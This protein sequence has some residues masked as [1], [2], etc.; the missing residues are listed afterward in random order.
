MTAFHIPRRRL[1]Q[2]AAAATIALPSF[3]C[4]AQTLAR[5]LRIG[6]QKGYPGLLKGRR[7]LEALEA[8]AAGTA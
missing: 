1:R 2:G 3:A 4:F 5:V 7:T 6:N 8:A